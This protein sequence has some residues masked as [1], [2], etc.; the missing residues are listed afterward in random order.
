MS[1]RP[2][3]IAHREMA[4][5]PTARY[6]RGDWTERSAY[7]LALEKLHGETMAAKVWILENQ[8]RPK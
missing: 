7:K 5:G 8:W 3:I 6:C 2:A 4:A 1:H